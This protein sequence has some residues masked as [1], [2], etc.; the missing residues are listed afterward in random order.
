MGWVDVGLGWAS[1]QYP[2]TRNRDG[3]AVERQTRDRKVLGFEG[4]QEQWESFLF[5]GQHSVLTPIS[6]M[7]VLLG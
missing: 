3:S 7:D 2:Q 1:G 4:W 5:Q 6:V